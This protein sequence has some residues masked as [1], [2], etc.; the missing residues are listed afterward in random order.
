MRDTFSTQV[1]SIVAPTGLASRILRPFCAFLNFDNAVLFVI[2]FIDF[3]ILTKRRGSSFGGI[4]WHL[5]VYVYI[6]CM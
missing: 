4:G 2:F 6:D 1:L 5:T 3:R